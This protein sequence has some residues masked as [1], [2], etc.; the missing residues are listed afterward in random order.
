M[1]QPMSMQPCLSH[2][3]PVGGDQQNRAPGGTKAVPHRGLAHVTGG[4][5]PAS[6]EFA[7]SAPAM[8]ENRAYI[9]LRPAFGFRGFSD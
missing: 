6:A 7:H 2:C 9:N 3:R 8:P 4:K 1:P 5:T